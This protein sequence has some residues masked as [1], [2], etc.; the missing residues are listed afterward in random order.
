[1]I[2]V[3]IPNNYVPERTYAIRTMLTH[4][5]GIGV[6]VIPVKDM[7]AYRLQ[8]DEKS[9]TI[10]DD[11]FGKIV[12]GTSYA[13]PEYLPKK[14]IEA[15]SIGLDDI[16][17]LY[18]SEHLESTRDA[19]VCHVDLFAGVFFMLT[20]WEES[21]GINEDPHD[22]FPA[23]KAAVV[24]AGF[25]LRPIVDE[26]VHLLKQWIK[27]LGY[28]IPANEDSFR[29]VPTCDVDI[30]FY[31]RSK[32][33]WKILGGRLRKHFNPFKVIG[34]Y[35]DYKKVQEHAKADPYDTFNDLMTLAEENNHQFQFNFI[36]G[37]KTKFEGYYQLE[38]ER[39][40]MLLREIKARGHGIGLHPSYMTYQDTALL[41]T[42][43]DFLE[44]NAALS[45]TKSRQHFLRFSV[46]ETWNN[47]SEAGITED[48]TLGYAAEPGFR[49]GT[50][51]SFPVFDIHQG[52]ALPLIE[53]PLL[54]M[55]VSLRFYKKLTIEE[56]ITLCEKIKTEVKKHNGDF[57]FLWHNSTLS[58]VDGWSHW[59]V[60]LEHLM[61]E[62]S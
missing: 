62:P 13:N 31:W 18:G 60:V 54:V 36:A 21:I 41:K 20:R 1:M 16:L 53:K 38:D 4:F 44:S 28:P 12:E 34:D 6:E 59:K 35:A 7:N 42:E 56:S 46:P 51:K 55:D 19:I 52:K 26:Y 24:A 30:P 11:F 5:C 27:T 25:I 40:Q 10:A 33:L 14:I 58:D 29:I 2:T 15:Q 39:I 23:D 61:T 45:I 57:I 49:C 22:R 47:L 8:W 17:I 50:S 43:K 37:G 3:H 32:P 48:S 9:I